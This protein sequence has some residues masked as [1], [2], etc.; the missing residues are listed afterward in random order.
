M[1]NTDFSQEN[2]A[3]SEVSDALFKMGIKGAIDGIHETYRSRPVAGR[4]LPVHLCRKP[5]W[6]PSSKTN[7]PP[8]T[9]RKAAPVE[10]PNRLLV[11]DSMRVRVA[12]P[13]NSS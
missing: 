5:S 8:P 4:A 2:L 9:P 13:A 10:L 6:S 1:E 7:S 12:N 3:S 11:N